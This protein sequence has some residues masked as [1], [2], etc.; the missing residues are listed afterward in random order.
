MTTIPDDARLMEC[1]DTELRAMAREQGIGLLRRGLP[2]EALVLLVSGEIPLAAEHVSDTAGT[3]AALQKFI[4]DNIERTR[5]QLPGCDGC[6]TTYPCTEGRHAL[7]MRGN[8]RIVRA[9]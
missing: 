1:N 7:C 8:E 2:K 4:A 6:C 3:R 5:S 9:R